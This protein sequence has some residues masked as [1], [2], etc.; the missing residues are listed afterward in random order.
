VNSLWEFAYLFFN[1]HGE[2]GGTC[3]LHTILR[4]ITRYHTVEEFRDRE[5]TWVRTK[6]KP[7]VTGHVGPDLSWNTEGADLG[8]VQRV[9]NNEEYCYLGLFYLHFC[10]FFES[11]TEW[12]EMVT[13]ISPYVERII[14]DRRNRGRAVR[15]G[16]TG[17]T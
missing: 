16:D 13:G 6:D 1:I 2:V 11:L 7:G 3:V 5:L 4:Q 12:E 14:E 10:D 17:R 15:D 9:L 8:L